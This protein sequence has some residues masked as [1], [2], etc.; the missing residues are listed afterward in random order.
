MDWTQTDWN[1][2]RGHQESAMNAMYQNT[3]ASHFERSERKVFTIDVTDVV[4]SPFTFSVNLHEPLKIDKLSDIYLEAFT[5]Y[6]ALQNSSAAANMA[7]LL[8]IDQFNI[9]SN[10][11][12]KALG[13]P[14]ASK[15]FNSLIIPNNA[16]EFDTSKVFVHKAKKL[17]FICSINP[18][19]ISTISGTITNADGTKAFTD[20]N[21]RFIAEFVVIS[22]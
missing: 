14:D 9:Q 6:G 5:T 8:K 7:F 20:S 15:M 22:R 16:N 4:T 17:N 2:M 1:S 12:I 11:G 3:G 18:T 10:A 21:G 19:T 13:D